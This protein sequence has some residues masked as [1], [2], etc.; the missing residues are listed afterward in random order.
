MSSFAKT[1]KREDVNAKF[2]YKYPVGGSSL[3]L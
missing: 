2:N 1:A 3:A